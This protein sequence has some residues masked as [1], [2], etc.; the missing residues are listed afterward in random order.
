MDL[1]LLFSVVRWLTRSVVRDSRH[2]GL[3]VLQERHISVVRHFQ[4]HA[5]YVVRCS[6][7]I[8]SGSCRRKGIFQNWLHIHYQRNRNIEH[9]RRS[10]YGTHKMIFCDR[11]MIV[12]SCTVV[13]RRTRCK[14]L[15]ELSFRK[16]YRV[17]FEWL[18]NSSSILLGGTLI[19]WQ[20]K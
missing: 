8:C 7:C 3:L 4:F 5:V 14:L 15:F 2:D 17:S 1:L 20:M 10:K 19:C 6:L 9:V 13:Y 12:F 18:Y 11:R 16:A